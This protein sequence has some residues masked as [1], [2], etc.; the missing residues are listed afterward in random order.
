VP[1]DSRPATVSDALDAYERDLAARGGDTYNAKRAR[2]YLTGSILSK[3][4]AL[5]GSA[6]LC[7]WR[8]GL[9][10]KLSRASIN[11]ARNCV[12]AAL[13]LAAKRDRRIANRHA[14]E[15]DLTAL[16]NATT[17][18][19]VVLADDVVARVVAAAYECDRKLGLLCQTLA[20]T[21][22]RP[23]QA[24]RL[25]VADL[26]QANTRLMMPRS[27]KGH[28]HKRATKMTERVPVP[29]TAA[30]AGLLKQEAK[31]RAS[32]APLLT[33]RNGEPWEYRRNDRYRED[34]AAAVAACGLDPKTTTAYSLRHSFVSR[35]LLKGVPVTVVADMTDTSEREIRKH[36]AKLISHHADE[37]ARRALIDVSQPPS[38]D[39]VVPLK[40]R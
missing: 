31:G 37:I 5:L 13:S 18:R 26:D 25:T 3:P 35:S 36:Y 17:A 12:R 9:I 21:G 29:I 22:A 15:E 34:F 11:R 39:V 14:W 23:S 27:G 8:D 2:Y 28:V 30:L 38:A 10:D 16:P 6:E 20:E 4:I 1:D 32:N 33:R 7:R 40:G 24:V 19:N